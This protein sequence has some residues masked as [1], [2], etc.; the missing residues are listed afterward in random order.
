[1][2]DGYLADQ[3]T[4][5]IVYLA[6][7]LHRPILIEGPPGAGKTELAYALARGADRKVTRLQCYPG[8][9]EAKAIGKFDEAL[10]RLALESRLVA[11]EDWETLKRQLHGEPFFSAARPLDAAVNSEDRL[12]RR[13]LPRSPELIDF[14]SATFR[15][16][17]FN[18]KLTTHSSHEGL[19]SAHVHVRTSFHL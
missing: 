11:D 3:I 6:A 9:D 4:P 14:N 5:T 15:E 13:S 2:A 19:E 8:I 7:T 1:M 12:A 18:V 16:H 10:Q 17:G